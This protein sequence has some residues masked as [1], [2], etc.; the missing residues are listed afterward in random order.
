MTIPGGE[1]VQYETGQT[2]VP[3]EK[4]LDIVRDIETIK[5]CGIVRETRGLLVES[6]GP[7]AS[8]GE[9]CRIDL[10]ERKSVLAEVVGFHDRHLL[11]MPLGDLDGVAPGMRVSATGSSYRVGVSPDLLGRVIDGF[12]N[13]IDGLGHVDAT[14][15][16]PLSGEKLNPLTRNRIDTPLWTRV[17]PID[18]VVTVGKGQ[19]IGIFAGSG[20]GK[21]VL[22]GMIARKV[23]A[24]VNVIALIGERGREVR[25]FLEKDLGREG[26]SRSVV[27]VVTS[28]MPAILRLQGTKVALTIAEYFR[29]LG[30]DVV[31]MMDSVTRVAMA[32]REVGLSAGE[33]PTTKG[34]TPSVFA[35][36]PK[37]LERAGT[38]DKGTITGVYTVLVEGDDVN[39]P[40]SDTVR[41]IID[42]HIVLS[43]RLANRGHYPAIDILQSIS[44]VQKDVIDD[45]H[46]KLVTR[47]IE[48]YADYSEA[49]DLINIG[50]YVK[51]SNPRIDRAINRIDAI[52]DFLRQDIEDSTDPEDMLAMLEKAAGGIA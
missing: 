48:L 46:R 25:E 29:S 51:G 38:S 22:L 39:E 2:A 12:G 17:R 10:E 35:L 37:I 6:R 19:R 4:Y 28:D 31:L 49:E 30:K 33:P 3:F 8:V 43:R 15:T 47:L 34:Y 1:P 24:D 14:A 18:G 32:Q 45:R 52:N 42:G 50:A 21:S 13:P 40:V 27:V 23:V 16:M 41:S 44:R 9:I 7:Q 5:R 26:L 11:L 20:V 36:M